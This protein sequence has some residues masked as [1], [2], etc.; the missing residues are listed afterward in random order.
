MSCGSRITLLKEAHPRFPGGSA[1]QRLFASAG[2]VRSLGREEPRRRQ[3]HPLQHS[4]LGNPMDRG[5]WRATVC[6]IT[7]RVAHNLATEQ[8][9]QQ[10]GPHPNPWKLWLCVAL[11]GKMDLIT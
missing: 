2:D 4:R 8:Q 7:K 11:R 6:G 1:A 10:T 5:A 3:W 9:Q